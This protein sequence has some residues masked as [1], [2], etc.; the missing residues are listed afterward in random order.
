MKHE[1]ES[2]ATREGFNRALR[3]FQLTITANDQVTER[4][5]I[6]G[7]MAGLLA[8]NQIAQHQIGPVLSAI[9]VSKFGAPTMSLNMPEKFSDWDKVKDLVAPWSG[10]E[11]VLAYHNPA[12]GILVVDPRNP[13]NLGEAAELAKDELVVL[14]AHVYHGENDEDKSKKGRLAVETLAKILKGQSVTDREDINKQLRDEKLEQE[15]AAKASQP[16]PAQPA[17]TPPPQAAAAPATGAKK[18]TP[19]YGV[20]VTN[21]LFHNGN[22][23]AW[24]NIIEAYQVTFQCKVLVF[25]EGEFIKDLNSL[26]K[27]GKV[28]HQGVIM[29]Q[30]V[31]TNIKG[32]SKLKKYLYEGASPR[33]ENYLK[34]DVNKILRLF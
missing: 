8:G 3:H 1:F 27:W 31:G 23:E 30:V 19:K 26:F 10:V 29:F 21:E 14:Y 13:V 25:Y 20:V 2:L 22:V 28:K 12:F 32:V 16:A 4:Q 5:N 11:M 6:A 24:K 7:M 17:P 18:A 9:L 34:H 33:F 15:K